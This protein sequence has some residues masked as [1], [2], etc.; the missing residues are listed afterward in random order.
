MRSRTFRL[1]A[2]G[3]LTALAAACGERAPEGPRTRVLLIGVDAATWHVARP[4]MERGEL[5]ALK[6]LVDRGT[7]GDLISMDPMVSPALWTTIATGMFP[8]RHGVSGFTQ[9]DATTGK[10]VPVSS[11]LRKRE[12]LWTMLTQ[13][14]RTANVVGWYA[15]WPA[16]EIQGFVVTD[17]FLPRA[18]SAFWPVSSEEEAQ[19]GGRTHPRE[20]LK[21]ILP[22]VPTLKEVSAIDQIGLRFKDDGTPENEKL[23]KLFEPFRVDETRFR[24]AQHLMRKGPWDLTM[25]FLWGID[26]MSHLFWRFFEPDSWHGEPIAADAMA[27]NKDKI[28]SY[29]KKIDGYIGRLV[30]AA[31]PETIVM[32]VSDHGFGPAVS[33][34]AEGM[35]LSGDHRKEGV[36]VAAGGPIRRGAR[37]DGASIVDVTPTILY[38]LGLPVGADMDG[39]VVEGLFGTPLPRPITT[40][41]SYERGTKKPATEAPIASPIDDEIR[42]QLRA[43]GYL[44]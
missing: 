16:E 23:A 32:V 31:G 9:A 24:V 40:V 42:Q 15:S 26:P 1:L 43:L 34:S 3:V 41:A 27:A 12:A 28:P 44:E 6:A 37:L 13:K 2:L 5:P 18:A 19:L 17:H 10:Q 4:M 33:R 21:E 29:Y 22:L 39:R 36:L 11:N 8:E 35:P 30:E 7:S 25:V 20:L 14:D 38:L